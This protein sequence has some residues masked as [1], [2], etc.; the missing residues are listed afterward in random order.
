MTI[1]NII[2]I[3]LITFLYITI[4]LFN[5]ML[6]SE[7][8]NKRNPTHKINSLFTNRW[9]PRS[10]TGEDIEDNDLMSLFEAARWAPSSY[11]NQP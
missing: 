2:I 11:N 8:D 4:P 7:V 5:S 10:M 1:N 3:L 6:N 9:S